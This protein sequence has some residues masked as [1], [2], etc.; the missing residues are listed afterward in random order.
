MCTCAAR[1]TRIN[2]FL[3]IYSRLYHK[4]SE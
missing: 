3:F 1:L 4:E 2:S